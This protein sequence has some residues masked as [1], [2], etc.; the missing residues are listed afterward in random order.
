MK[1]NP[2]CLFHATNSDWQ[3]LSRAEFA[4]ALQTR[5]GDFQTCVL[6]IGL[7]PR[8]NL[9]AVLVRGQVINIYSLGPAPSRLDTGDLFSVLPN[10]RST[11][12]V[13][14]LALTPHTAR[15][16]KILL[17][18]PQ[19]E[20]A[21]AI[22]PGQLEKAIEETGLQT[23]PGL[24]H[25]SWPSAQ[26]L[27]LLPGG[28]QPARHTLFIASNQIL[29]SAGSMTALYGWKETRCKLKIY[30][31]RNTGP[32][33]DEYFLHH[34][35]TWQV[36]HL[37]QRFEELTGRLVVNTIVREMNFAASANGW[38]ITVSAHNITDQAVFSSP[39]QAGQVYQRLLEI[40]LQHAEMV[41]GAEL[42]S[43]LLRESQ[44]RLHAPYRDVF[45]RYKA[46]HAPEKSPVSV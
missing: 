16:V 25:I 19:D 34:A 9:A 38:N 43:M 5:Q 46:A 31:S 33:W 3:L 29:H 40:V 27:A 8:A 2:F 42:L 24:A 23:A 36:S 17:E 11:L 20:T 26:G 6:E 28:G 45:E 41:L 39:E 44:T 14:V 37:F 15:M 18:Q 35:F 30:D 32:A 7:A 13:R 4:N 12:R 10:K 1:K 21:T 22:R